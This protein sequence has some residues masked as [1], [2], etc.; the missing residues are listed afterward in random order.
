MPARPRAVKA[1]RRYAKPGRALAAQLVDA[2]G[3]TEVE[4]IFCAAYLSNGFHA[5]EAYRQAY[6]DST[7]NTV[8]AEAALYTAKPR[9]RLYLNAQLAKYF[10]RL[11]VAG[12]EM[13]GRVIQDARSDIRELLDDHGNVLSPR[14]WPDSIA[15]S[16]ESY[17][18]TK[19]GFKVKLVSK[20]HARRTVLELT[21]KLKAPAS[22]EL[23]ILARALRGDLERL[24][25]GP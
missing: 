17:E 9:V 3:L 14:L 1:R 5:A 22:E 2:D 23:S 18:V 7:P 10:G 12:D 4:R 21:G 25:P 11:Q 16:V 15:N 13:L 24:E 20:L 19:D 8:K 6:P